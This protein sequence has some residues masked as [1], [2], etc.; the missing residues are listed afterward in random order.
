MHEI[1]RL[2]RFLK[3]YRKASIA[4]LTMLALVVIMDL[5]IPRF[6]QQIIDDGIAKNDLMLVLNTT[7]LMLGAS[8]LGTLLSIG[9]TILSV[10][11]SQ[12]FA[13]DLRDA[14]FRKIQAFSFG[15]LD[16]IKTGS[17]M[18]RLTSDVNQV[19]RMVMLS[20]RIGTRAPLLMIGSVILMIVTSPRLALIMLILMMVTGVLVVIFINKMRRLFLAIQQKL[21]KLNIML[22][23]NLAG[24]RVVKAFVRSDH[25]NSRF[26]QANTDLMS[27]TIEVMQLLSVLMPSMMFIIN[28][29]IVSV[30]WFGGNLVISDTLT[31]GQIVAFINYLLSTMIYLMLVAMIAGLASAAEASASRISEVLESTPHIQDLPNARPISNVKGRVVFENIAFSYNSNGN[32]PVL[33]GINL[34]AEPGETVAILGA[35]GSGKSTLVQLIPRFYEVTEGRVTLDDID[36]RKITQESLQAQMGIALQ[37]TILFRGTIRDNIRYGNPKATEEEVIAAAKVTQAHDFI[38]DLRDGYDSMVG[39]RGIN[40]SGGQKQ[41]I[42]IARA[43][44]IKPRILILDDSTSSVDVETE[45]E[46]Q[47]ALDQLVTDCTSFIIAQRISTVLR[48]DKII[49]LDQGQIAAE[50]THAELI[51]TSPIYQEIYQSQLGD[52]ELHNG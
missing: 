7:L 17:L 29:G 1:S 25:E 36:I 38:T 52:G 46:I 28:L 51:S 15:N 12:Y 37:D 33:K 16:R 4:A 13:C 2:L 44:L 20:L 39:Q 43:L 10:R 35:T 19:Q 42:A 26:D 48:A 32:E 49:V 41:R 22:Q 21:D 30:V 6:V 34:V 8:I 5:A 18:V 27:K 14:I 3:P 23:E 40:L 50:G 9:N 11:A 31:V 24:I 45:A 47:E